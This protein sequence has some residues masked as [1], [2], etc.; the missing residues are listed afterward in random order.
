MKD[1]FYRKEEKMS[2]SKGI[3][4]KFDFEDIK[5]EF[6]EAGYELLSTEYHKNTDRMKYICPFHKDKGVQEMTYQNFHAGKR[7]P[8]CAHR[9]RKT[10]EEYIE[11]L[12]IKKPTIKVVGEY[13][14]L[15][16][17]IEHECT[18]CGYH[19]MVKPDLL[20]NSKNGCPKCGRRAPVSEEE[21]GARLLNESVEL[22]GEYQGTQYKSLFR[23]KRCGYEWTAKVNNILNGR[24]CPN[25]KKSHGEEKIEQYLKEH[26][27][28]FVREYSFDNCCDET[29][30]KFDFYLPNNNTCIEFD[31]QQHFAPTKFHNCAEKEAMSRLEK[32]QKH[33]KIKEEYCLRH[34]I[35]L[36]RIPYWDEKKIPEILSSFFS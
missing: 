21:I 28:D 18:V 1:Y 34:N 14:S 22:I 2:K 5:K 19:W 26:S 10:Q 12:A 4:R 9:K 25:C 35:K 33:D 11:E 27:I 20:L 29:Y 31:G 7:C 13:V 36:L 8:Y 3:R 32:Q 17:K 23:C 16:T 24:R 30:L 6:E 15:K